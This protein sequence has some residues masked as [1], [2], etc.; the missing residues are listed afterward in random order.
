MFCYFFF[1]SCN[2]Q[3]L[4]SLRKE[5]LEDVCVCTFV[6]LSKPRNLA[7]H[8]QEKQVIASQICFW[9]FFSETC[10]KNIGNKQKNSFQLLKLIYIQLKSH[11]AFILSLFIVF[12]FL[13]LSLPW[14]STQR[15]NDWGTADLGF[16]G[17]NFHPADSICPLPFEDYSKS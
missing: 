17:N 3:K 8:Y 4:C 2:S 13:S 5:E 14:H 12:G 11:V 9:F 10:I 1:E 16:W 6:T 15:L 7:Y